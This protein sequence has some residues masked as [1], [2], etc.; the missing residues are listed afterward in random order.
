[1]AEDERVRRPGVEDARSLPIV[2]SLSRDADGWRICVVARDRSFL[3]SRIAGSLSSFG[4]G[5]VAADAFANA[6]SQVLDVFRCVDPGGLFENADRRREFQAFLEAAVAGTVD[7]ED[8]LRERH[9]ELQQPAPAGFALEWDAYRRRRPRR[10]L[11][12]PGRPQA[13]GGGQARPGSGLGAARPP[14]GRAALRLRAY[15]S[16]RASVSWTVRR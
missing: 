12:D 4:L 16:V 7:L 5:I 15:S 9:P 11:P 14:A 6:N 8:R 1:M 3:F 13:G 2:S 10:L